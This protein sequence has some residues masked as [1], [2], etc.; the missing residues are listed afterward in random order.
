MDGQPGSL[1]PAQLGQQRTIPFP[2]P[3]H[4]AGRARAAYVD[5]RHGPVLLMYHGTPA[6]RSLTGP[7]PA[8]YAEFR[9]A[10]FDYQP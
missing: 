10:A 4:A 6:G 8:L 7:H 9:C 1:A 3:L 5:E 2:E